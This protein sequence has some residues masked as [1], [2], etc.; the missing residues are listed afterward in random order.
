MRTGLPLYLKIWKKKEK[1]GI[2]KI[3]EKKIEKPKILN[4]NLKIPD[5]FYNFYMLS[6]KTLI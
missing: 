1:P 4:K 3:K 5:F 2:L 6:S